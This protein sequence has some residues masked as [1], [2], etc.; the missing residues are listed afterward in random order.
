ML[1]SALATVK[2]V[3]DLQ[4]FSVDD[5]CLEFGPA[6]SSRCPETP[7]WICA[8]SS[9]HALQGPG[10]ELASAAPGGGR[11]SHCSALSRSYLAHLCGPHAELQDL[12]SALCL[13]RRTAEGKSCLQTKTRPLDSGG[14][15][16][17]LSG[18][19]LT[20]PPWG[21]STLYERRCFLLALARGASIADICKA[22]GW[23]TPNTFARFYNL[24][25]EPVSSRVLVS[26]GQ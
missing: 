1:L 20:V 5:S 19:A 10:G 6:D 22:A 12:R 26:D 16:L 23:A 11:P 15:S 13:L 4:A 25:I 14:Y 24:R 18:P 21:E 9:H 8:Q 17:G 3:G 7:A 2:R